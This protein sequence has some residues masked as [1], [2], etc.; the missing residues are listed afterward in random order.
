MSHFPPEHLLLDYA[1]FPQHLLHNG[2]G[3]GKND[4]T[5]TRVPRW[6]RKQKS[7]NK[8]KLIP[9]PELSGWLHSMMKSGRQK[10][11][12]WV[13]RSRDKRREKTANMLELN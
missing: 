5:S 10:A 11:V 12:I 7:E 2:S 1:A 9:T 3:L 8:S 6:H 4:A 13:R